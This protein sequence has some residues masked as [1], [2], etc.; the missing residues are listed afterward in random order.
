MRNKKMSNTASPIPEDRIPVIVGVGEIVDRPKEIT[1][2]LE[3][4][5]LLEQALKHAETDSGGKL[6]GEI[7][8]LAVVKFLSCRYPDPGKPLA[9]RRRPNPA[10]LSYGPAG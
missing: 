4:L 8:S 6:L 7:G 1:A 5:D 10:H 3:P 9:H 2:G